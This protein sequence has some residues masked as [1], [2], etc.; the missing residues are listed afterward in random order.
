MTLS[1]DIV[2]D[3]SLYTSFFALNNAIYEYA[4]IVASARDNNQTQII[5]LSNDGNTPD[6]RSVHVET[7]IAPPMPDMHDCDGIFEDAEDPDDNLYKDCEDLDL[8]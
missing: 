5:L 4:Q 1:Y 2:I 8:I 7:M 6:K 3:G